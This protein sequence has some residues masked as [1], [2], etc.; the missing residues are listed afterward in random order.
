MIGP[1]PNLSTPPV[2]EA[3]AEVEVTPAFCL[4]PAGLARKF[5]ICVRNNDGGLRKCCRNYFPRESLQYLYSI[6]ICMYTHMYAYA[7]IFHLATYG[8]FL[9]ARTIETAGIR[10]LSS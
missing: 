5:Q 2:A 10:S 8:I 1:N 6:S 9:M 7:L 3:D 4:I